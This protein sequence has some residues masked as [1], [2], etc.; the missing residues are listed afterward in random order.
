MTHDGTNA[1]AQNDL[2]AGW[3]VGHESSKA[4]AF[5]NIRLKCQDVHA[6]LSQSEEAPPQRS[7]F[8]LD[9]YRKL[10]HLR[11]ATLTPFSPEAPISVQ[12][13]SYC[14]NDA[15]S[16]AGSVDLASS[17]CLDVFA[18]SDFGA[19]TSQSSL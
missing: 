8:V 1:M 3:I 13:R 10:S 19:A 14:S 9:R 18:A 2:G 6:A 11:H 4:F 12:S 17:S 7:R 15:A 16:T 5:L